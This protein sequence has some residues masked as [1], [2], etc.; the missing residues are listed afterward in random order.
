M[1]NGKE[2]ISELEDRI[3]E[4]T[5]SGQHAESQMKR[6]D[7]R[8]IKNEKRPRQEG[9]EKEKGKKKKKKKQC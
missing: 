4:I 3:M 2:G 5:Q 8:K 7:K 6:R 1:N 9:R